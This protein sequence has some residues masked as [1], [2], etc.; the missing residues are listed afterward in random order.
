MTAPPLKGRKLRI[1]VLGVLA[2]QK[3]AQT[4]IALAEA[5]DPA[6]IELHL[7]GYPEEKL[8][9]TVEGR[10]VMSGE[11]DEGRPARPCWRR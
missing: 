10:I 11:Y 3:G 4:L 2:D 1:A 9:E 7:I 8:P 6:T 5:T